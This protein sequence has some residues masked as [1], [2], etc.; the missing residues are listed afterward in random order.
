MN[1]II[2]STFCLIILLT[3]QG[4][5]KSQDKYSMEFIKNI[6]TAD[7]NNNESIGEI[8][9]KNN[10]VFISKNQNGLK[11]YDVSNINNPELVSEV[12]GHIARTF[13]DGDYAYCVG[14]Q[15]FMII[16]ITNPN[17]CNIIGSLPI[18]APNEFIAGIEISKNENIVYIGS[19][20]R[21]AFH[22]G[23][24][25]IDVTEPANPVSLNHLGSF[26]GVPTDIVIKDHYAFV[27]AGTYGLGGLYCFDISNP[28][29]LSLTSK[30]NWEWDFGS[31]LDIEGDKAYISTVG[32][33]YIYDISDPT[34]MTQIIKY[35]ENV[36]ENNSFNAVRVHQNLAYLIHEDT[37][38][39]VLDVTNPQDI[40]PLVV[41]SQKKEYNHILVD[42]HLYLSG[43]GTADIYKVDLTTNTNSP[44][45][46]TSNIV[47]SPNPFSDKLSIDVLT[48]KTENCKI[49]IYNQLGKL[50]FE[51]SM[52]CI[53]AG[54]HTFSWNAYD[55]S[56]NKVPAGIYFCK[57]RVGDYKKTIKIIHN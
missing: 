37:N 11:V 39:A 45:A 56:K 24:E 6:T 15:T 29:A 44:I 55:L 54:K 31:G 48:E 30:V 42:D 7:L 49:A 32:G 43:S 20:H 2:K 25:A 41:Y 14:H 53:G 57:I 3:Y 21:F 1:K 8:D 22:F 4:Q 17:Q 9:F 18:N 13:I 40:K 5:L 51:R 10:Y 12:D 33:L 23:I 34:N 52:S 28:S 47:A 50:I 46:K 36:S 16:D 27:S 38:F 19:F 35:P 26:T